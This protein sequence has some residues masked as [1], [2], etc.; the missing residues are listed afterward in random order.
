[1]HGMTRCALCPELVRPEDDFTRDDNGRFV[2]VDCLE[3]AGLPWPSGWWAD[4]E[5]DGWAP[6]FQIGRAGCVSLPIWFKTEEECL[7][8]M[9]ENIIGAGLLP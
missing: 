4:Q 7:S 8:F 9:R 6:T 5:A 2:H 1:M 3:N